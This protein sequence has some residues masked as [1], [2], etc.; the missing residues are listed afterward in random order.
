M[1]GVN[2]VVWYYQWLDLQGNKVI[3]GGRLV[4]KKDYLGYV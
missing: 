2:N 4:Q 3:K 1:K